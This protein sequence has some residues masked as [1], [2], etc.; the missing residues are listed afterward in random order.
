ME[1]EKKG[2]KRR[3]KE[4]VNEKTG[5]KEK[6]NERREMTSRSQLRSQRD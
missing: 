1:K 5:G 2:R 6:C 3:K 4:R